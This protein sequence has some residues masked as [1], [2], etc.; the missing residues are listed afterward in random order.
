VDAELPAANP[1]PAGASHSSSR[2][3]RRQ[4][5]RHHRARFVLPD[6]ANGEAVKRLVVA[7]DRHILDLRRSDK[8]TVKRIFVRAFHEPSLNRMGRGNWELHEAILFQDGMKTGYKRLG[9]TLCQSPRSADTHCRLSSRMPEQRVQRCQ[10]SSCW[11]STMTRPCGG[12]VGPDFERSRS[13]NKRSMSAGV[14]FPRPT[15]S[16]VPTILRT[17]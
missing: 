5:I 4:F 11:T 16:S 10:A 7:D 9:K 8:H 13:P 17:M 12:T 14:S 3:S 1:L 15:S 2:E 6:S